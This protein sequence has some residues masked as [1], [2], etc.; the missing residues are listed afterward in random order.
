VDKKNL[1]KWFFYLVITF[2]VVIVVKNFAPFGLKAIYRFDFP[3]S[4]NIKIEGLQPVEQLSQY[5]K[6]IYKI[7]FFEFSSK[8]GKF[9]LKLPPSPIMPS[10]AKIKM[11][12][13]S[14]Q[15][16][17]LG[18]ENKESQEFTYQPM[19]NPI[20]NNLNWQK[21]EK[22][23]ITLF[24]KKPVYSSVDSFIKNPPQYSSSE[25][26]IAL[27]NT[28]L[29]HKINPPAQSQTIIDSSLRGKQTI[30]TY[31]QNGKLN[32]EVEKQDLNW[33]F[34][35]DD[36]EILVF[37]GDTMVGEKKIEDDGIADDSKET[38]KP[39]KDSLDINVANGIYK[40]VLKCDNDLIIKKI[41]LNQPLVVFKNTLLADNA[42][43]YPITFYK[44]N[45]VYTDSTNIS[46]SIP[47]EASYQKVK[48]DEKEIELK[49]QT[50]SIDL[51]A[52]LASE[53]ENKAKL[54][55]IT[56]DKNDL[57][58]SGDGVF[59]FNPN[60]YFNPF[61]NE[62]TSFGEKKVD[63]NQ[64]DY[65]LAKYKIPQQKNGWYYQEA[66]FDLHGYNFKDNC[67]SF[68][69]TTPYST[70][71]KISFKLKSLEITIE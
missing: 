6:F 68:V 28:I 38:A 65:I 10:K 33:Q 48:I 26:K 25:P 2:L 64:I 27:Y 11:V 53:D 43:I 18:I 56:T 50:T 29:E 58:I 45:T 66:E 19:F 15:E 71:Q 60:S 22:N 41:T 44:T 61:P 52:K 63:L 14:D 57:G 69:I 34:G 30:Y 36:L 51:N 17:K 39:Q 55:E 23:D 24:E 3:N 67:L 1:R 20:L 46:L 5:G 12:F 37:K 35:Q 16:I 49:Q 7:P 40:I 13:Q 31:V 42:D 21:V 70:P 8:Q 4:K 9:D 54:H 62:I 47:H 32:L 59:A